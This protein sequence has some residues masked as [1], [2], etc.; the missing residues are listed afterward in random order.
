VVAR[1]LDHLNLP[2]TLITPWMSDSPS[3]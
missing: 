1:I 3:P 2:Q